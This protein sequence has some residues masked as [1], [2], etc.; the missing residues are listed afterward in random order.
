MS[1]TFNALVLDR[2]EDKRI[3]AA[4]QPLSSPICRTRT[5]W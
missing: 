3:R 1:A 2:N 5:C 4:I